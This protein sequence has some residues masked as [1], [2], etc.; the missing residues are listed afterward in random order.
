MNANRKSLFFPLATFVA[1]AVLGAFVWAQVSQQ[2]AR[3]PGNAGP[4]PQNQIAPAP[5]QPANQ[6]VRDP[7]ALENSRQPARVDQAN[8]DSRQRPSAQSEEQDAAWLGVFLRERDNERGATVAHVYPSGPAAR[9]GL[10]PGDVIQQVNGQ[11]VSNGNELV[12]ALEQMHPGD[13]AEITVLRSNEPTKLTATLGSRDS[14][15]SR[16]RPMD[17]FYGRGNQGGQSGQYDDNDDQYNFPLHAMEL[18]HNRRNAE[19]HQRIENE[20]AQLREEVRQL[21]EA[22]QR[23]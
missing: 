17:R 14:F 11:Q 13:K 20:I 8:S 21:R 15:I 16:N 10:Y 1:V 9:A 4:A 3:Q 7:R 23:R 6:A 19:Q 22:L 5:A 2:P 12:A 18:E